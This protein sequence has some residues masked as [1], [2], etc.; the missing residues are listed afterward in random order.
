MARAFDDTKAE[1][2]EIEEIV[3][4][5]RPFTI[6]IDPVA[7]LAESSDADDADGET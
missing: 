1:H 3:L 6:C 2:I 5:A 4:P 7:I